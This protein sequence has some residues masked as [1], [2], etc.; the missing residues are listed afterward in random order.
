MNMRTET[1][2]G[3]RTIRII[4]EYMNDALF[5]TNIDGTY[6]YFKCRQKIRVNPEN[7]KKSATAKTKYFDMSGQE[8]SI[9]EYQAP[10][11]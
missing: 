2:D 5:I 8:L 7:I 10:E 4:T 3:N 1:E 6:D 9:E 11:S